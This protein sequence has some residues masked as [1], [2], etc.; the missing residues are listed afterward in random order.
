MISESDTGVSKVRVRR[1]RT[2]RR[3]AEK[4]GG[5]FLDRLTSSFQHWTRRILVCKISDVS[6]VVQNGA[7]RFMRITILAG[8]KLCSSYLGRLGGH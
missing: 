3:D 7:K 8:Y 2:K 6:E 4:A 1:V 5:R